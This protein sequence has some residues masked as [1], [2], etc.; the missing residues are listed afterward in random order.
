MSRMNPRLANRRPIANLSSIDEAALMGL[1]DHA[2]LRPEMTRQEVEAGVDVAIAWQTATVCCR[3]ADLPMV[4]SR[5]R[6]TP[7]SAC[8]VIGFPHGTNAPSIKKRE[9]MAAVD[10]GAVEL[11]VVLNFSALRSGDFGVVRDELSDL[12]YAVAPVPVKVILE[13]GYLTPEQVEMA[14]R[15]SLEARAAFVK[16]GTGFSPRGAEPEEIALMRRVVGDNVGV[17]AA[18]GIR[19]LDRMLAMVAAGAC[20]VGASATAAIGDEWRARGPEAL[21]ALAAA[22]PEATL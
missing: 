18:G 4:V 14:C 1:I 17:K 7:V 22:T 16:N 6:R 19:N 8:T 2:L 20:R 11:D 3:P 9:A 10:A 13:T 12:V 21:E 15:I 5:L